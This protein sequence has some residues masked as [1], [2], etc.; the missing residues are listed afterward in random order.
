VK[1]LKNKD[2]E[3][4][5]YKQK[6]KK[7]FKVVHKYMHL[8]SNIN[9]IRKEIKDHDDIVTNICNIKK[10]N[11]R[12]ILLVFYELKPENNNKDIYKIKLFLQCKIKF[13][14]LLP[15]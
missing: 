3:F 8:S 12:K 13:E 1:E 9:D 2:T 7:S 5:T 6:Q 10:Q 15:K 11:A 14:L 4:H